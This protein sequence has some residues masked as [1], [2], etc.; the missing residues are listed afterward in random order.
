MTAEQIGQAHG[1]TLATVRTQIQSV[2][3]KLGVARA[4][5][6]VRMLKQGGP[7]WAATSSRASDA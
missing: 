2:L 4:V 7:L 6:V 1:T 5:D 3:A